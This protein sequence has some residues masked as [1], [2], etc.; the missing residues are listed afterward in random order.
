MVKLLGR[1]QDAT[2]HWLPRAIKGD[3][4]R[5][6]KSNSF[7]AILKRLISVWQLDKLN[8]YDGFYSINSL[9]AVSAD[10]HHQGAL[11]STSNIVHHWTQYQLIITHL[12]QL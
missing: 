12:K 7:V 11:L 4:L 9:L 3:D 8:G 1:R 5:F 2:S 6:N 10:E